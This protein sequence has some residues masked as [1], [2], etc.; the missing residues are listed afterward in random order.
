M[1]EQTYGGERRNE[2]A[3]GLGFAA[4][5]FCLGGPIGAAIGAYIGAS[6]G[7]KSDRIRKAEAQAKAPRPINYKPN[8]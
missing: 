7:N 3:C 4:V 5:G 2:T 1:L 6:A 8:A